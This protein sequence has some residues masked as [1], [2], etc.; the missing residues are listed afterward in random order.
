MNSDDLINYI[1]IPKWDRVFRIKDALMA[2]ASIKRICESTKIDR[3]FIYQIQKICD[4]EKEIAKYDMKSL[5]DDLLRE[6]KI[7]GFSDEQIA[8]IMNEDNNAA[9]LI[10][11]RRK[12]MGLLRVFKMVDTCAAEFEAKTPYF[13][14]TFENK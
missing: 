5:P 1:K 11:E 13:Y 2:G 12:A 4:C 9:D 6:A 7:L 14:S 8:K 10:Y 3:W